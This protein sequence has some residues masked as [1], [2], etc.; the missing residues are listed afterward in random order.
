MNFI[1]HPGVSLG[2]SHRKD[3]SMKNHP[4]QC[5]MILPDRTII[6]ARLADTSLVSVAEDI[7]GEKNISS[8]DALITNQSGCWLTITVADCLPLYFFDPEKK[9]VAIAHAG[10]RGV[11]G[12]I[13]GEL[14][15]KFVSRYGS[16]VADIE[17]FVGPHLRSCHFE[18]QAD[19][20]G[21]FPLPAVI[22]RDGRT[23]VDLTKVVSEQLIA[24]GVRPEQ[25]EI[26]PECTYCLQ[27]QYFSWRRDHPREIETMLAY[28]GLE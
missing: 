10:W 23:F 27:D 11:V 1:D 3:G 13:A 2:I 7:D 12:N 21:L 18:V 25:I 24:A 19:L 5:R 22:V 26:S 6:S 9:V 16:N 28:I 4:E 15:K 14:V 20:V 8:S 17:V